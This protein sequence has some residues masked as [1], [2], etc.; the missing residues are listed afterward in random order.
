MSQAGS[1]TVKYL[2]LDG[3]FPME[4]Y[5]LPAA[6]FISSETTTYD[7]KEVAI[8]S[9]GAVVPVSDRSRLANAGLATWL[10]GFE[11]TSMFAF[12]G[13]RTLTSLVDYIYYS[14]PTT[15]PYQYLRIQLEVPAESQVGKTVASGIQ[16]V[17]TD[18]WEA[19]GLAMAEQHKAAIDIFVRDFIFG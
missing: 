3:F 7:L 15:L 8:L 1:D 13:T 19:I 11:I 4:T 5:S 17:L 10:Q 9:L 14:D 18:D 6:Y 12:T 2:L 16:N